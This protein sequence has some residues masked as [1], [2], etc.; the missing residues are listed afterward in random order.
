MKRGGA[1]GGRPG[2]RVSGKPF[3]AKPFHANTTKTNVGRDIVW[4]SNNPLRFGSFNCN[5]F[6]TSELCLL[7]FC[8]TVDLDII[9]I[10]EHKLRP[11]QSIQTP[12]YEYAGSAVRN[13]KSLGWEGGGGVGF[14]FKTELKGD[15]TFLENESNDRMVWIRVYRGKSKPS[16]FLC[17]CYGFVEGTSIG[18]VE[19]WFLSLESKITKFKMLGSVIV[20][21]DFNARIGKFEGSNKGEEVVNENG[22]AMIRML[23]RQSLTPIN[24]WKCSNG[25]WT[26]RRNSHQ[27]IIDYILVCDDERERINFCKVEEEVEAGSD[28]N[29][30]WCEMKE[31]HGRIGRRKKK[32]EVW[33]IEKLIENPFEYQTAI[34]DQFEGWKEEI[35]QLRTNTPN[36]QERIDKVWNSFLSKILSCMEESVGK[37]V[38]RDHAKPWWTIETTNAK[39]KKDAAFAAL[40][41]AEKNETGQEVYF[42]KAKYQIAVKAYRSLIK[43]Q[44][45]EDSNC[46]I[47][48]IDVAHAFKE[49]KTYWK[50]V[51][52]MRGRKSTLPQVMRWEERIV[53][54]EEERL[55]VWAKAYEK[56]GLK[57]D[58]PTFNAD[59]KSEVEEQVKKAGESMS[60]QE[61]TPELDR[62]IE[63]EEIRKALKELQNGKAAGVDEVKPE[64][65]KYGGVRMVSILFHLFSAIWETEQV[66]KTWKKGGIFPIFK[67]DDP[68]DPANYRG[69]TLLSVPGKILEKI[70][71]ARLYSWVEA[72]EILNDEEGG[73]RERRGCLDLVFMLSEIINVRRH[74]NMGTFM[75]FIDVTKAYD[76]VWLDGLWAK[77]WNY[78]VQGRMWRFIREW[79]KDMSSQVLADGKKTRSFKLEQGVKQGAILSPLLYNLFINDIVKLLKGRG[80][81]LVFEG[82]WVGIMMYADDMVLLASSGEELQQMIDV[83]VEF[84]KDWRFQLSAPKSEVMVVKGKRD[85]NWKMGEETL[86][87]SD[88]FRYLGVE[89]QMNGRWNK[90]IQRRKSQAQH[91]ADF[92]IGM[93]M[94]AFGFSAGAADRLWRSLILPVLLY[95]TEITIPG[96]VVSKSAETLQKRV[97]KT[98]LGC[99]ANVADEAVRGE[100]GWLPIEAERDINKLRFLERMVHMDRNRVVRNVFMRRK[101]ATDFNEAE[102]RGWCSHTKALL[103]KY[104]LEQW[105]NIDSW[106]EFPHK[107]EWNIM[108][109]KAVHHVH[110]A[111]WK[112]GMQGKHSLHSYSMVKGRLEFEKYL[113]T[114]IWRRRGTIAK[115]KLRVGYHPLRVSSGRFERPFVTRENRFCQICQ[116]GVVEDEAHHLI[117]CKALEAPREFMWSCLHEASGVNKP[118]NGMEQL[119]FLLGGNE[120]G[121]IPDTVEKNIQAGMHRLLVHRDLFID[122]SDKFGRYNKL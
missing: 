84:S 39:K 6:S 46:F 78:G 67:K 93:G 31:N 90:S 86:K 18:I 62:P 117:H 35:E 37:K 113:D 65:L 3:H 88:F 13:S 73:F 101:F 96:V 112:E 41:Q 63:F 72:E 14:L 94:R 24:I 57:S 122:K 26:W 5:G 70:L 104:Q 61:Y 79:Y 11:G 2:D 60:F 91:K 81:G 9:A 36:S 75:C 40:R 99:N 25:G 8:K 76:T 17:S 15:I 56:L 85:R 111:E 103:A 77:L 54:E 55:E 38:V 7:D 66:P 100:L 120:R 115:T 34:A 48:K 16:I 19:G 105:W 58:S 49:S 114:P 21:G 43:K 12:G 95:G 89:I 108:V 30:L 107:A 32:I 44:K 42:A 110:E 1:I 97:G 52:K 69:I 119:H 22:K 102:T 118:A 28:H 116:R 80:L 83:V 23:E 27:S 87:V 20:L 51:R 68:M 82:N 59:F 10:S 106:A 71:N 64:M 47:D 98:I 92:L 33:R 53:E 45:R 4:S 74:A 109:K 121:V 50:H 29:I